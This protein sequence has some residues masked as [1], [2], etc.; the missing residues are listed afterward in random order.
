MAVIDQKWIYKMV[1]YKY[2]LSSEVLD[3]FGF[4]HSQSFKTIG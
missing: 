2:I 4:K 1:Y 3:I